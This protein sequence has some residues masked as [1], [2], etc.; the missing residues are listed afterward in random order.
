MS[1]SFALLIYTATDDSCIYAV[2]T[3]DK[4]TA[5]VL[6]LLLKLVLFHFYYTYFLGTLGG[7]PPVYTTYTSTMYFTMTS[8]TSAGF[9]NVAADTAEEMLYCIFILFLGGE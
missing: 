3:S 9:G 2:E 6:F 4:K 5:W 7:G 8:V 1:N